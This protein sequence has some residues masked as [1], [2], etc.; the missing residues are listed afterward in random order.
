[1]VAL[2]D[3]EL[4]FLEAA[5]H[6]VLATIAPD[7]RPRL[8]PFVF[9]SRFSGRSKSVVLYSALDE[10]PKTVSDPRDLARVRDIRERPRVTVLVDRYDDEDWSNLR[11]LRLDGDADILEPGAAEHPHA[12]ELLRERY[13]QYA[14]HDLESRP[15]I[16]IEVTRAVSWGVE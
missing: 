13:T 5:R 12:V 7:G 9:A 14:S 3:A 1:V 6:G 10:K 16:R 15:V 2:T 11:W 4:R 8:V